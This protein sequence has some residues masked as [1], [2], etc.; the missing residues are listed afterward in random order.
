MSHV[1]TRLCWHL[2]FARNQVLDYF[3]GKCNFLCKLIF[4]YQIIPKSVI[5]KNKTNF[6]LKYFKIKNNFQY[7]FRCD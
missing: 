6:R 1:K 3:I 5:F 2:S 4:W 7:S